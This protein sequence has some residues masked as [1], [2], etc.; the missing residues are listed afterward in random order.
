MKK[1]LIYLSSIVILLNSIFIFSLR[2]FAQENIPSEYIA[3]AHG[4]NFQS[5]VWNYDNVKKYYII[6]DPEGI[7]P[8]VLTSPQYFYTADHVTFFK[9][10]ST[11]L[12]TLILNRGLSIV[13]DPDR[14]AALILAFFNS[15]KNTVSLDGY[16]VQSG[17]YDAERNFL[18]YALNDIDGC[19][20]ENI[21]I[22]SETLAI[23][24]PNYQTYNVKNFYDYYTQTEYPDFIKVYPPS[25]TYIKNQRLTILTQYNANVET[26]IKENWDSLVTGLTDFYN[27]KADQSSAYYRSIYFKNIPD[28]SYYIYSY[29]STFARWNQ[30]CNFYGLD[31][32][33]Y[34]LLFSEMLGKNVTNG[35][36]MTFKAYLNGEPV[37]E[38]ISR[39]VNHTGSTTNTIT[40]S[41]NTTNSFE[42]GKHQSSSGNQKIQYG[43]DYTIYK[44]V[45]AY[46]SVNVTKDYTPTDIVGTNYYNYNVNND[47]SIHTTITEIDNSQTVNQTIYE[48]N[49]SIVVDNVGSDGD[50]DQEQIVIDID[51]A[52]EQNYPTNN[53]PSDPDNPSDPVNPSDPDNPLEDDTI[54]D[55]I[56]A[57]LRRFFEIIGRILGTI[58][59]GLLE[60]ID[61]VLE[62]IAGVMESLGGVTE[63]IGSLFSWIP[64]PVPQ[65]LGLGISIC[66]LAAIFKFIRG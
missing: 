19:Y 14:A 20:Y 17:V 1:L 64:E 39:D 45:D 7:E 11:D 34:D 8:S 21:T 55:A 29:D 66:I 3:R 56:L 63:F 32:N 60:V 49:S 26:F 31:K 41:T 38:F 57:A 42:I 43:K 50:I 58:L 2:S 23:D 33:N 62:A 22:P 24:I 40:T 35:T 6:D 9:I 10:N 53:N 13:L 4:S 48:D 65:I 51:I 59:A 18:G 37:T 46:N 54:L 36:S 52:I 44:S 61:S 25:D 30:F 16:Y 5:L 12:I 47:N 15:I 27:I 28:G